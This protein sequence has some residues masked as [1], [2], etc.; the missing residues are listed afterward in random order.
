ME[1][2]QPIL[3]LQLLA[4]LTLAN[5]TPVI[6]KKILGNVLAHPLDAG[7]TLSDG[8]PLLGRSKT[9]RGIVLSIVVTS[10]GAPWIGLDWTAG[11]I[12]AVMA[13]IGDLI[14]SFTKRRMKLAPSSMVLGLDQV[15]E[16]LLPALVSR[17]VL[18]LTILDI[19]IVTVVFFLGEL[20]VSRVLFALAIRDRP[21]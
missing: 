7:A 8:Q 20:A 6:A 21:Y 11:L 9:V 5:G 15:P 10:L 2:I 3:V 14:S 13:M 1:L 16:S 18:P 19:V 4:L 17:L 12:V